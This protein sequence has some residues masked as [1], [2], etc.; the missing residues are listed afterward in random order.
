MRLLVV[1]A[2]R[3]EADAVLRGLGRGGARP[4]GPYAASATPTPAGELVVVAA[5]VGSAAAAAVTA[6][7][8]T[9]DAYDVVLSLGIAGGFRDRAAVGEV[10][11]ADRVAVADLGA[12][13]PEGFEQLS[14]VDC[15][16]PLTAPDPGAVAERLVADGLVARTGGI[17]TVST[18]TGTDERAEQLAVSHP[19]AIAEAMEG[20]GVLTACLPRGVPFAEVRSVS[21][22]VE[23]RNRGAWDVKG[24]LDTLS[25]AAAALFSAPLPGI[26]A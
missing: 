4:L 10:V 14:G 16:W 15:E 5:G 3:A 22:V 9:L 13:S 26:P 21:N 1:T 2:V 6:T 12:D 7:A 8:L 17:L 20:Y 19:T 18:V 25:A 24:A 23:R 11:I